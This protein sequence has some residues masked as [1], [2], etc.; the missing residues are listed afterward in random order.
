MQKLDAPNLIKLDLSR[1]LF[2]SVKALR[3]VGFHLK[4]L[5]I[6]KFFIDKTPIE[7]RTIP[8]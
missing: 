1:N 4:N 5:T 8:L 7:F 3:K 6:R 2:L